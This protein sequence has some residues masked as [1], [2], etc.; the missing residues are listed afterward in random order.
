MSQLVKLLLN[1]I[2]K[3]PFGHGL[4]S[5]V[6]ERKRFPLRSVK[7]FATNFQVSELSKS[8]VLL[9]KQR[10]TVHTVFVAFEAKSHHVIAL[11]EW[12]SEFNNRIRAHNELCRFRYYSILALSLFRNIVGCS[13]FVEDSF[14]W[15]RML[16]G[17]ST[18]SH[19]K[20]SICHVLSKLSSRL[21][22]ST[23]HRMNW[24]WKKS[25]PGVRFF[26]IISSNGI[27]RSCLRIYRELV[28]KEFSLQ[29]SRICMS[30]SKRDR[31]FSLP[32]GYLKTLSRIISPSGSELSLSRNPRFPVSSVLQWVLL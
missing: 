15:P 18:W 7:N 10:L 6:K 11:T 26:F 20:S 27:K 9:W 19:Q 22:P 21:T 29:F 32:C 5:T 30:P 3:K 14:E 13:T 23:G 8:M 24:L 31:V 4:T 2:W 17:T 1:W 16:L 25:T 12:L 28:C